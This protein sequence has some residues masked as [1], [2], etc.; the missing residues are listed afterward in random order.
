MTPFLCRR[1]GA[2]FVLS[3]R[4]ILTD[5]LRLHTLVISL[6]SSMVYIP[7]PY[8]ATRLCLS[9]GL[10]VL[11]RFVGAMNIR[12]ARRPYYSVMFIISIRFY[13]G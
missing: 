6:F 4:R 7:P 2:D 13:A 8:P 1:V 11:L 12:N 10:E 3:W 9:C 5:A